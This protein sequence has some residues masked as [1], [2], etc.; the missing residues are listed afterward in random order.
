MKK[1]SGNEISAMVL[2]GVMILG[3]I[4]LFVSPK[5]W[6]VP[7]EARGPYGHAV[8]ILPNKWGKNYSSY[9]EGYETA[10]L[11]RTS[12]I[13]VTRFCGIA[14]ITLGVGLVAMAAYRSKSD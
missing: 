5:P 4:I 9:Q 13:G 11:I 2:G 8:I 6:I 3:G 10:A 12:S 7:H 1:L 14:A